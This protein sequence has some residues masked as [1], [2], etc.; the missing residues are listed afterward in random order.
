MT[1]KKLLILLE[2]DYDQIF[3]EKI[4]LN[5]FE[6]KFDETQLVLYARIHPKTIEKI[7]KAY[8]DLGFD[9]I[10]FCDLDNANCYPS[11]KEEIEARF[12]LGEK[13][14]ILIVIK[15]IESWILAGVIKEVLYDVGTNKRIVTKM[16]VHKKGFTTD[17][18]YSKDFDKL[19][20]RGMSKRLFVLRILAF[21]NIKKAKQRN[22]SFLY[23]FNKYL[24]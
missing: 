13:E 21:F 22:T 24:K 10:I 15:E 16:G 17:C 3:F 12:N 6:K 9:F 8:L 19:K 7:I 1:S 11:K 2:S 4:L 20:P 18:V 23:F 5:F 14:K